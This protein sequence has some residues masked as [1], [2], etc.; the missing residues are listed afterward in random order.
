MQKLIYIILFSIGLS[1][2]DNLSLSSSKSS[3]PEDTAEAFFYALYN[4]KN[5][6]KV[7]QLS[8]PQMV[9]QL[10]RFK[11]VNHVAKKYFYLSYDKVEVKALVKGKNLRDSF[12]GKYRTVEVA[13]DGISHGK[14]VKEVI[15]VK[16]IQQGPHWTVHEV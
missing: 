13:L 11:T 10:S 14:R 9:E 5:L 7:Q 1:A 16:L 15:T 4:D 12:Q 8:S 3:S 2:C 6:L